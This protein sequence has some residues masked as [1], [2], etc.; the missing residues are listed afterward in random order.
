MASLF[1]RDKAERLAVAPDDGAAVDE[2]LS[3]AR[4]DMHDR[5]D[6]RRLHAGTRL[7]FRISITIAAVH[8]KLPPPQGSAVSGS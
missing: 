1:A 2:I 3:L 8:V 6:P 7:V 5:V 4:I